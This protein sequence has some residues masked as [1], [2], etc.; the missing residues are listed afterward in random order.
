MQTKTFLGAVVAAAAI[1]AM[2]LAANADKPKSL[3]I[4]AGNPGT[5]WTIVATA[6]SQAFAQK[7]VRANA[8]LGGGLSNIVT[9]G[10]GK[11]ETGF[12]MT[13]VLPLAY[14]G[15]KPFPKPISNITG[16]AGVM[17]NTTHVMVHADSGVKSMKDFKGKAF[18]SQ[19]VGNVTT[20]VFAT[21]LEL[22]GLSENDL[23]LTRGGQNFGSNQMKDRKVVGFTATTSWPSPAFVEASTSID[24]SFVPVD[25]ATFEA[26]KKV[27]PGFSRAVIPANTYRGQ[28]EDVPTISTPAVMIIAKEFP[29]DQVYWI[30]KNLA[31]S[32]PQIRKAYAAVRDLTPEKMVEMP[33]V[34]MHPGAARYYKEIGLIKA[35]N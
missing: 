7:G 19:P 9:I 22:N 29:E 8:E 4:A 24:V 11:N 31:E 15:E 25:D 16:I 13:A 1:V 17:T 35:T 5:G 2:P 23:K 18:A 34:E 33:A 32:L 6:I 27:N 12:T 14:K 3:R 28:T 30:T 26:L 21:L 20:Y 10:S